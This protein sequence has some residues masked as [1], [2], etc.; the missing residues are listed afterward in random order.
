M[1]ETV[2]REN[3][4]ACRVILPLRATSLS[5]FASS[6]PLTSGLICSFV[7]SNNM[8]VEVSLYFADLPRSW[9]SKTCSESHEPV[10]AEDSPVGEESTMGEVSN[11]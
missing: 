4:L 2:E 8:T 10:G 1:I 3:K 11:Q 6:N 5:T 9:H 7:P